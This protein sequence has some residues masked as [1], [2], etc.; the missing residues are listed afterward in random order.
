MEFTAI[1][2]RILLMTTRASAPTTA[3]YL[4]APGAVT[5]TAG[6]G[7]VFE[8]ANL[9]GRPLL[10]IL[11]ISETIEQE[12]LQVS[13]WGSADG[14][15]WGAQ[16]LFSFP[17]KF[18]S[19]VTPAALDLQLRPEVKYLQARWEVDRWGRGKPLPRFGFMVE[20]QELQPE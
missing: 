14:Q 4:V 3:R 6:A 12:S 19:G 16:P 11:R 8:L 18:Y 10:V 20:V 1:C 17:Q 2:R 7:A 5:E 13:V 9:A 15:A